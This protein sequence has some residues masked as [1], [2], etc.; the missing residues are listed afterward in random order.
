MGAV[1]HAH[2]DRANLQPAGLHLEDVA[3][4]RSRI[5]IGKNK[6]I[7]GPIKSRIGENTVTQVLIQRRI[8]PCLEVLSLGGPACLQCRQ[9][10]LVIV[11]F[12][13]DASGLSLPQSDRQERE[14]S[15]LDLL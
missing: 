13:D 15:C 11:G 6:A 7:C 1:A 9:L 8:R 5:R 10:Q 12:L 3:N 2:Q 4:A 14:Q